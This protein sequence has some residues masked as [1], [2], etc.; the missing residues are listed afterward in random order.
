MFS[1]FFLLVFTFANFPSQNALLDLFLESL[2]V[3][4][5]SAQ[6]IEK[7]LSVV[8]CFNFTRAGQAA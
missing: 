2:Y 8:N 5:V 7:D 1:Y 4:D 6:F 3:K